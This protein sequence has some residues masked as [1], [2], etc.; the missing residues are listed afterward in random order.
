[1]NVNLKKLQEICDL[2][3]SGFSKYGEVTNIQKDQGMYIHKDNGS[4]VL[5][6]AHLDTVKQEKYFSV[7]H[8]DKTLVFSPR[9]D[10]RLG[11]Y[12]ILHLLPVMGINLDILL[13]ENEEMGASTGFHFTT[14]KKYNWLVEFDRHGNDIVLYDYS[15]KKFA[16]KLKKQGFKIGIGSYTDI[17]DLE[18]LGCK[19]FNVGVS[20]H[21]EHTLRC[22][23]ILQDYIR[24]ISKFIRFYEKYK[25]LKFHHSPRPIT[26]KIKYVSTPK[27]YKKSIYYDFE[28]IDFSKTEIIDDRGLKVVNDFCLS[29]CMVCGSELET[30]TEAKLGA[31]WECYTNS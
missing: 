7:A 4:N 13:T 31:C 23:F 30:K 18:H 22:Y 1:M 28:D 21:N 10:D 12:T 19:G 24:Q 5:A 3:I 27:G 14:E 17:S 9:L 2:S 25:T 8:L 20:Y 11:V 26:E 16:Q 29:A 6:V 15:G